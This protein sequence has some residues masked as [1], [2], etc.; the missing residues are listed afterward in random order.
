MPSQIMQ[1]LENLALPSY[2]RS[3]SVSLGEMDYWQMF[4]TNR[5]EGDKLGGV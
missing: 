3:N 4:V 1:E 2:R 5:K